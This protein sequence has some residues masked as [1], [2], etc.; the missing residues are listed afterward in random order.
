MDQ[1]SLVQWHLVIQARP[2]GAVTGPPV[3]LAGREL[4]TLD[5]RG[6]PVSEPLPVTFDAVLMAF[7]QLGMFVEG[8]GSFCWTAP[9][10]VWRVFGELYDGSERLQY[11]EMKGFCPRRELEQVLGCFGNDT[12][13]LMIQLVREGVYCT[14]E[15]MIEWAFPE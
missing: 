11:A 2:A 6:Q 15:A 3:S 7:Q 4:A 12:D 8:D 13:R 5:L 1:D 10:A 14:P 9:Q